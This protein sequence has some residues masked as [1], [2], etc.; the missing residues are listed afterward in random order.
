M[1][2]PTTPEESTTTPTSPED[3]TTT[4]T[5]PEESTTTNAAST[6][7]PKTTE[8]T[9]QG[10]TTQEPTT[11][12]TTLPP[13][14]TKQICEAD[15]ECVCRIVEDPWDWEWHN[16]LYGGLAGLGVM[17]ILILICQL[18]MRRRKN[19]S[20]ELEMSDYVREP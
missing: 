9:T 2:I 12:T 6:E 15:E 10:P 11:S 7:E 5:T 19:D 18:F 8:A 4:P 16:I 3:S 13:T 1:G 17:L 14:T 20:F